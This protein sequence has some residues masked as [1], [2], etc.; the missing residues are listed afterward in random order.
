MKSKVNL[1]VLIAAAIIPGIYIS[2]NL[3]P[4]MAFAQVKQIDEQVGKVR[5][6]DKELPIEEKKE[7]LKLP[8][9]TAGA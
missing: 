5:E 1:I 7:K 2:G 9:L 8:G 4:G 6:K 3:E